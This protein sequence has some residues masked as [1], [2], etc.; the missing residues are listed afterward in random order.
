MN[1]EKIFLQ[2]TRS[3]KYIPL[4]PC[5]RLGENVT[6]NTCG[7][8]RF[9]APPIEENYVKCKFNAVLNAPA[10]VREKYGLIIDEDYETE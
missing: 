8:C 7:H 9:L 1:G 5:P 2:G 4:L 6:Q 3:A 10:W